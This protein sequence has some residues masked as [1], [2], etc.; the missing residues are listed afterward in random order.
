MGVQIRSHNERQLLI[1][2]LREKGYIAQDLSD[3]EMAKL[4]IRHMVGGRPPNIGNELLYRV[5]FPERPGALMAFLSKLGERWNISL[6]HYR[7]HGA[8]Y[9]RVL[10]GFQAEASA[11]RDIERV[12]ADINYP[13]HSEAANPA[14]QLFLK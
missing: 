12:L 13:F 9:G 11:G 5:E 14:Y 7:N 10:L 6:F 3:N 1:E 4:H 2:R 8:A